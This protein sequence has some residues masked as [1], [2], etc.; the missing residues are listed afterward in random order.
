[1]RSR[2]MSEGSVI[3]VPFSNLRLKTYRRAAPPTQ[4]GCYKLSD[5]LLTAPDPAAPDQPWHLKLG[6]K[7]MP[8]PLLLQ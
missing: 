6:L 7:R 4:L 3:A 5:F 2:V 1:M 8:K